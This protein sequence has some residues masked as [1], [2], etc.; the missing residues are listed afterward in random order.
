M[1]NKLTSYHT[2]ML[3]IIS[4][5]CL[6]QEREGGQEEGRPGVGY[7]AGDH[8]QRRV[9]QEQQQ[10]EPGD[11]GVHPQVSGDGGGALVTGEIIRVPWK[12]LR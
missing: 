12:C 10:Q 8:R 3:T 1:V 7:G 6:A 2:N 11:C 9:H 5:V 4:F